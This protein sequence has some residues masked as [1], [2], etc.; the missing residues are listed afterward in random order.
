M[1]ARRS[2]VSFDVSCD[3]GFSDDSVRSQSERV[4]HTYCYTRFVRQVR[5]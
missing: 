5:F 2:R 1:K 3:L 4:C